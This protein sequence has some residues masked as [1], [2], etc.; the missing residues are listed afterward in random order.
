MRVA[1]SARRRR[2]GEDADGRGGQD[3]L[4]IRERHQARAD[5]HGV[6]E[7]VALDRITGRR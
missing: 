4:G 1:N 6:A 5:V 2:P 7:Y 3:L